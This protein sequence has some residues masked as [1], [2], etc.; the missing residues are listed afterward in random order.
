MTRVIEDAKNDSD[1]LSNAKVRSGSPVQ[2]K[3][4]GLVG[5]NGVYLLNL[6][7][8]P[9]GVTDVKGD[10]I[11]RKANFSVSKFVDCLSKLKDS[12]RF[13]SIKLIQLT[14]KSGLRFQK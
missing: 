13:R 8:S 5:T 7:V 3:V 9:E 4:N 14:V 1:S 12:N 6:F 11:A 2:L 10:W